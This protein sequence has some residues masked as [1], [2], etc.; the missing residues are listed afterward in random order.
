MAQRVRIKRRTKGTVQDVEILT[1][2]EKKRAVS[3]KERRTSPFERGVKQRECASRAVLMELACIAVGLQ[4]GYFYK[5][6]PE[7]L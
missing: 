3:L 7:Q 4:H 1:C 5:S 2:G 6:V